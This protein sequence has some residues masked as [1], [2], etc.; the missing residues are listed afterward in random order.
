L[1][2]EINHILNDTRLSDLIADAMPALKIHAKQGEE[3]SFELMKLAK[4]LRESVLF[5]EV[6]D[7]FLASLN[8]LNDF[9][10]YLIFKLRYR[11]G[12]TASDEAFVEKRF[13]DLYPGQDL[14]YIEG[15]EYYEHEIDD[16]FSD[17]DDDD[18]SR[19]VFDEE[20]ENEPRKND[21]NE[22]IADLFDSLSI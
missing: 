10:R 19:D 2:I 8:S 15:L 18:W 3:A 17:P 6:K 1:L 13:S 12:L 4:S 7:A 11:D 14:S 21:P 20:R 9:E 16:E 5:S 22:V